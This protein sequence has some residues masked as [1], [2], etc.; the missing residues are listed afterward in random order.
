MARLVALLA[1]SCACDAGPPAPPAP[2]SPRVPTPQRQIV[3]RASLLTHDLH[4]QLPANGIVLRTS[5]M[6]DSTWD[7]VDFDKHVLKVRVEAN[8]TVRE[9]VIPLEVDALANLS[10][11]SDRTWREIQHGDMPNAFDIEQALY[12]TADADAFYLRGNPIESHAARTGRPDAS[13]L[14]L[15]IETLAMPALEPK[16]RH[17]HAIARR[18]LGLPDLELADKDLP[19][20]GVILK[21]WGLGGDSTLVVDR[22]AGTVRAITNLVGQGHKDRTRKLAPAKL[23]AVMTAAN[24]AWGETPNGEMPDATDVRE[25]LYVFDDDEAFYL[26]G[27]P[28][29]AYGGKGRPLAQVALEALIALER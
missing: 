17:A 11:L 1:L 26:S 21:S 29:G 6:G 10:V 19:K 24:A 16:P 18:G 25:D 9:E 28:I 13:A 7:V 27:H 12:L 14:V 23:E 5:G 20:H 2:P 3:P 22:D 8:A 4:V 15:A